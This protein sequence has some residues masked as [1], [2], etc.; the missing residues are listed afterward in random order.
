MKTDNIRHSLAVF[1]QLLQRDWYVYKKKDWKVVTINYAL[2]MPMVG[3]ICFGYLVPHLS[4]AHPNAEIITNFIIGTSLW[5]LFLLP[6]RINIETL[7]DLESEQFINYQLGL[8]R[9][10][11]L[12]IEKMLFSAFIAFINFFPFILISKLVLGNNFITMNAS[13]FKLCIITGFGSLFCAIFTLFFVFFVKGIA[14]TNNFFMRLNYPLIQFG[15]SFI[16]WHIMNSYSRIV[17]IV[18]YANPMLYITEGI[19]QAIIGG[20]RFFSFGTSILGLLTSCT[21]FIFATLH[22]FR[23][24]L[25]PI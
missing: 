6:F 1:W 2:I 20:S 18:T 12:L 16:P 9:P 13:W 22:Y 7:F 3:I 23:K 14:Q 4:M 25:D 15:G 21:L 8:I 10:Q 24:K 17:G 5:T 11:L 19:R